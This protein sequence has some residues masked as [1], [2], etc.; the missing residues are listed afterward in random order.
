M[1][2]TLSE[3]LLHFIKIM[4]INNGDPTIPSVYNIGYMGVGNYT[5]CVKGIQTKCY[6]QWNSMLLRCYD[7]KYLIKYPTY[8]DCTVSEEW[9]NF[10]N[11]AKWYDQYNIVGYH[12]DKDLLVYNNKMYGSDTCCFIPAEINAMFKKRNRIYPTGVQK[13]GNKFRAYICTHTNTLNLGHFISIEEAFMAYKIAKETHIK[14]IANK[15]KDIID[16]RVYERLIQYQ[17]EIDK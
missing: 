2:G 13:I 9:H 16:A 8:K 3:G 10:Q 7:E 11:F 6:Q 12:L 14:L 4:R 17:I 5:S 1:S 15:Y